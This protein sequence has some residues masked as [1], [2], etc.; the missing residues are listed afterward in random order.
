MLGVAERQAGLNPS[1]EDQLRGLRGLR[2]R[3]RVVVYSTK[4][5]QQ[6]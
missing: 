2:G 3:N 5:S 1:Q 4:T 6:A